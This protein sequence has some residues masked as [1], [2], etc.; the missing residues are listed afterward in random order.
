[1]IYSKIIC[2]T[3]LLGICAYSS[4]VDEGCTMTGTLRSHTRIRVLEMTGARLGDEFIF[5]FNNQARYYGMLSVDLHGNV[6]KRKWKGPYGDWTKVPGVKVQHRDGF[7]GEVPV[8]AEERI[9]IWNAGV[10]TNR[11]GQ[12]FDLFNLTM[13]AG[14]PNAPTES[15]FKLNSEWT[16]YF[17]QR[18][19]SAKSTSAVSRDGNTIAYS[20]AKTGSYGRNTE[21]VTV[22]RRTSKDD[23]W[24]QMGTQKYS[25]FP[26]G[27][28]GSYDPSIV[29][30]K[31][32]G[33]DM[34][35]SVW[36]SAMAMSADGETIVVGSDAGY[37]GMVQVFEWKN[38]DW[39]LK[40]QSIWHGQ[41]DRIFPN[42][43]QNVA[44]SGDGNT[45][46]LSSKDYVQVFTFDAST[47]KWV[48]KGSDD[49]D[50]AYTGGYSTHTPTRISRQFNARYADISLSDDG[51]VMAFY[52]QSGW[53]GKGEVYKY[54]ES[55]DWQ[56]IGEFEGEMNE[57]YKTKRP[58]NFKLSADGTMV[59]F[60]V[61]MQWWGSA[62]DLQSVDHSRVKT[63]K[64]VDGA[65]VPF[66]E[67]IV[68]NT[69]NVYH[70]GFGYNLDM[71]D[72]GTTIVVAA[73][74][75]GPDDSVNDSAYFEVYD[76]QD[77]VYVLRERV[78]R[79]GIQRFAEDVEMS[80]DGSVIMVGSRHSLWGHSSEGLCSLYDGAVK[81]TSGTGGAVQC[82][83]PAPESV[84]LKVDG[85]K[86]E[87]SELLTLV[88]Q[89]LFDNN[90]GNKVA[91]LGATSTLEPT[92]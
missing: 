52:K 73:T 27:F 39:V 83:E 70:D 6:V 34:D 60:T 45:F 50:N 86:G 12:K 38:D 42:F 1:M 28:P 56:L 89:V 46:A 4:A 2:L 23:P 19:C 41:T 64:Y 65:F 25:A 31:D 33:P 59:A 29:P 58:S 91:L 5:G 20:A 35:Y 82:P 92:V 30:V 3:L 90:K 88:A 69:P 24:V 32:F 49:D 80:G 72:D 40:G 15:D 47:S 43:G 22:L 10:E 14:C 55:G 13:S 77:G 79:T 75:A 9:A 17:Y 51:N 84:L 61:R 7:N 11:G 71:S 67:D 36:G 26:H 63:F 78:E 62:N 8:P 74:N 21:A 68:V 53:H 18:L 57:N 66:A 76:F 87:T 16:G 54:Q 48:Q 85:Y 44:I 37:R 81:S